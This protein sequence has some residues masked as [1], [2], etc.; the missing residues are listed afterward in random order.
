[1]RGARRRSGPRRAESSLRFSAWGSMYARTSPQPL[2]GHGLADEIDG[3]QAQAFPGLALRGHAGDGHDGQARLA[4]GTELEEIEA[5]EA[6]E[7]DIEDDGVGAV[8]LQRLQRRFRAPDEQGLV[9]QLQEKIA[10]HSPDVGLVIHH[11]NP[12]ARAV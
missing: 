6:G 3:A 11:E 8:G 5:R 9:A 7:M 1:M 4:H 2:E 12:H 10:K